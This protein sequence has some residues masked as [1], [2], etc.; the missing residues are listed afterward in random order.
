[1]SIPS[2]PVAPGKPGLEI[3]PLAV[4]FPMIPPIGGVELSAVRA[5]FYKHERDDLMLVRFRPGTTCAGVFTQS[6]VGSAP[7]DW[8]RRALRASHG[9]DV[10]ALVLNAGCANAFTGKPGAKA[11]QAVCDAVG[12]AVGCK[13]EGVMTA[14]TGVIGVP[15]E[16]A[17]ITD[18]LPGLVKALTPDGW[19]AAARA[20]MTT[21]T[22]P[23]GAHASA[24]IDG[25]TVHI[26]GLAKGS[27]MIAPNMATMLAFVATDA[28]IAPAALQQLLQRGVVA[29][30][31]SVTV[32]GDTST[33]DTLLAFATGASGARRIDKASD[34]RLADFRDK[35]GVVLK[36]LALQLVRDGEGATKLAQI[37]VKGAKSESSA[38]KIALTIANSPLVKT[39]LAG[40]DANWGRVV[41]AAGRAGEPLDRDK[42][43][44]QF[45]EL[46]AAK[47][48]AVARGYDEAQMSAYMKRR[49]LEIV[50]DVGVGGKQ[51][52]VWTCDLT[53]RY[54][55]INGDYRS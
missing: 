9:Q 35:L 47:G 15:L 39:A 41:A 28:D 25:V 7:V 50:V 40:E 43:S 17:K 45:G 23:K 49:E 11:V 20:M 16:A 38:R 51:A 48:G 32:D 1:M 27:G 24:K 21:D 34:K 19:G 10:R 13:A 22:F 55:E 31:N 6:K 36:A 53:K 2:D 4:G 30:F 37:T 14:S 8:C 18:Q 5:G 54:I 3:S 29:T 44:V 12:R 33:N 26:A 42:L 52:Q 46:W